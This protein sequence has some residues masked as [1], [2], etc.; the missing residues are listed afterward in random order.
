MKPRIIKDVPLDPEYQWSCSVDYTADEWANYLN[1]RLALGV[2]ATPQEAY[3]DWLES[4]A[5]CERMKKDNLEK[6]K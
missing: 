3:K 6:L 4:V 2:G 1:N 5:F